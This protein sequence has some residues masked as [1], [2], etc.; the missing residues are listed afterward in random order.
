MRHRTKGLE[1]P[2]ECQTVSVPDAAKMIGIGRLRAYEL[3][4]NGELGCVRNGRLFRIPKS[5]IRKYLG[6]EQD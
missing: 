4:K 6:E 1:E 2:V 3:A 5:A